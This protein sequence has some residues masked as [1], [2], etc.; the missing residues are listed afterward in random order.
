MA[1]Q[2]AND[3]IYIQGIRLLQELEAALEIDV[4]PGD[5]GD[6]FGRLRALRI[7]DLGYTQFSCRYYR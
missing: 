6:F 2:C 7:P 1:G 5:G 4:L 3:R